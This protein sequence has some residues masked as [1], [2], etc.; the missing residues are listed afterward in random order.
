MFK[1]RLKEVAVYDNTYR[2]RNSN[3]ESNVDKPGQSNR[4]VMHM[5]GQSSTYISLHKV[6]QPLLA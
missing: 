3:L 4:G 1:K 6:C 2:S 5:V